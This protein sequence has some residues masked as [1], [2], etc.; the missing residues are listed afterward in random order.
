MSL[1]PIRFEPPSIVPLKNYDGII[2]PSVVNLKRSGTASTKDSYSYTTFDGSAGDASSISMSVPAIR[3]EPPSIVPLKNYDGII[4]P[5]VVNLK[6]SGTSST[7]DSY[8]YTTFDGST[9]DESSMTYD[10]S[11]ATSSY[12]NISSIHS[13]QNDASTMSCDNSSF[14][15]RRSTRT[16]KR[17]DFVQFLPDLSETSTCE[18]SLPS[19]HS[20]FS[21]YT[22]DDQNDVSTVSYDNSS[23]TTRRSTRTVKT[24]DSVQFLPDLSETST[25]EDSLPSTH[26]KFS[27]Y[28]HDDQNGVSTV[29]YDNSSLTTRRSTRTVK[30][31]DSVQFLHDVS[32]A[33][34]YGESLTSCRSTFDE[35]K[36]EEN[37]KE[38]EAADEDDDQVIETNTK[39]RSLSLKWDTGNTLRL[40]SRIAKD[41]TFDT[42]NERELPAE[43]TESDIT[44]NIDIDDEARSPLVAELDGGCPDNEVLQ[45]TRHNHE[46]SGTQRESHRQ[47]REFEDAMRQ[48]IFD[49]LTSVYTAPPKNAKLVLCVVIS[50]LSDGTL[51]H[52]FF[53]GGRVGLTELAVQWL[54]FDAD[55]L[56]VYRRGRVVEKKDF[57]FGPLGLTEIEGQHYLLESLAP[58]AANKIMRKVEEG[59][60]QNRLAEF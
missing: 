37:C 12:K 50:S 59:M 51:Q 17:S 9:G 34:T 27:S 56:Q 16:L 45:N 29:S 24:S 46:A 49:D 52:T 1:P 40:S 25:C 14:T 36:E 41:G 19:T 22:H 35:Q 58:R 31:S 11:T 33:S 13:Y 32:E 8:S 5:S 28:T 3:F 4:P 54:L 20:K 15:S 7:K 21:S 42:K 6:R 53:N 18:D 39:N 48:R 30:T 47:R 55:D 26:S 43:V 10:S 60:R 57:G 2:P 38:E 44:V 23:L